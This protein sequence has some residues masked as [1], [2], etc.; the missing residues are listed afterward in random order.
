MPFL[1]LSIVLNMGAASAD[2]TTTHLGIHYAHLSEGNRWLRSEPFRIGVK[3][4]V[5]SA[6]VAGS[7]R[8]WRKGH[9]VE[10]VLVSLIPAVLSGVATA[11]NL[12]LI[13][14]EQ[15]DRQGY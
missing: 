13:R 6:T 15:R 12:R 9:K 3:L 14:R 7:V 1:I 11:H 2:V 5:T 8:L 4:G 10:A